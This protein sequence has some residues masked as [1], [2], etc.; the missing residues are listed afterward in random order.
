MIKT[1]KINDFDYMGRGITRIDNVVT[2]VA[3][4]L[5]DEIVEIKIIKENKK[6]QEAI[7]VKVIKANSER[8]EALCPFYNECGGCDLMHM[9][10][11]AQLEFKKNKVISTLK[12]FSGLNLKINDVIKAED[13]FNYRNK[14]TFHVNNAIGFFKKKS[15][16]FIQVDNCLICDQKI[17]ELL[18]EL[19]KLPLNK[20]KNII[21][22]SSKNIQE[23]MLIVESDQEIEL[24]KIGGFDS[25]Y[26]LK[27]SK[28]YL[29]YGN[30]NI[31][32][33]M[34]DLIFYISPSAFFQV[35]TNQAIK[36]YN[37]VKEYAA[38][39]S[40]ETL[41]DLYCG[42]GTI[43]LYLS[44]QCKKVYGIEINEEAI[45]DANFNKD[46]NKIKNAEFHCLNA[47][48]FL[49]KIKDKIDVVV[50]DPPRGGLDNKTID[51]I[52]KLQPKRLIYVSCDV[53]TLAR[54]LK[55]LSEFYEV[56]EVTPVDM[57]PN[58]CHV[59]NVSLLKLR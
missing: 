46:K 42:T 13:I 48:K 37:K 25:I 55:L 22:R 26:L 40:N 6:F 35:N 14:I 53:A 3:G 29:K 31:A 20:I 57:F 56:I 7:A 24:T 43:A 39:K 5:L 15:N 17:N 27:N 49:N 54:D 28:Y 45:K 8:V 44:K 23:T 52:L 18:A 50:V 1:V 51:S 38:L 36:L 33:K 16:D 12:K 2:F 19:S 47:N 58:T 11:E 32:E 59:E 21:I 34:N 9:N 10:Y 41:L 30:K 4:A